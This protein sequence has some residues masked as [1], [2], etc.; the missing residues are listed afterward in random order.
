[1]RCKNSNFLIGL[2]IGSV[3][4]ALVYHFSHTPRA[5]RLRSEMCHAMH[6]AGSEAREAFH[7]AEEEALHAGV[8][9][10]DKMADEAHEAAEKAD[11]LK[12]KVHTFADAKK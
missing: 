8:K 11:N 5:A 2:G 1:M 10:A 4:G 6:K 12:D 7:A 3:V 9:A